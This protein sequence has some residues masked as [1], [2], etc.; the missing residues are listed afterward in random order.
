MTID[1]LAKKLNKMYATAH[2]GERVT[3]IHLFGVRY[4]DEI[5]EVGVKNVIEQ[6]G[7]RSSYHS[8]V[9]KGM[10]L[11]KYVLLKHNEL[12]FIDQI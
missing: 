2:K 10:R 6:S 4:S 11:A 3:M 7:I 8:E 12:N 9:S 1:E 5:K